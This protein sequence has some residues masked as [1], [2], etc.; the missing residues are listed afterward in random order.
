MTLA[1]N[2]LNGAEIIVVGGAGYIGSHVSKMIK[3]HGGIPVTFD[4]FSAGHKHAVQWGSY[5]DVDLRDREAICAAFEK[6]P[7]VNTV[8]HLASSIEVGIGV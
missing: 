4:N 6:Y 7:A 2:D 3:E 5:L 1:K 8:I